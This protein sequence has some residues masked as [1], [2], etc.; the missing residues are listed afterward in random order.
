[1]EIYVDMLP[2][3]Q[4]RAIHFYTFNFHKNLASPPQKGF[5]TTPLDNR[6]TTP[7]FGAPDQSVKKSCS[8]FYC[9]T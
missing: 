1:M 5:T 2:Y 7:L 9:F 3:H 8:N 6:P 4:T